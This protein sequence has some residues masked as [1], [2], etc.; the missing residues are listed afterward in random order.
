MKGTTAKR[1]NVR[2]A[3]PG[4]LARHRPDAHLEWIGDGKIIGR[5]SLWWNELPSWNDHA[6]G[7]IGHYSASGDG[8][9]DFLECACRQLRDHGCT[10]AVGP[11]DG[12]TWRSYRFVTRFG[13][14][15]RFFFEPDNPPEFVDHFLGSGFEPLATYFSALN[16]D[17][18]GTDPRITRRS[19]HLTES[20]I[21]L[22]PIRG[23]TIE[24]D[25]CRI[26]TVSRAAFRDNL[27]YA[28]PDKAEFLEAWRPL[29][30]KVPLELILLAEHAGD[31]VGFVFAIPDLNE[32]S[33]QLEGGST[34]PMSHRH[35]TVVIK[36]LA[37]LPHRQYAGLG[38]MLLAEVLRRALE[39]GFS[40]AIHAL[41]RD[42][43]HLRR[44][45]SRF[46][47]PIREYTLF[48]RVLPR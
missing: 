25:L 28:D 37:A 24:D 43:G 23:E 30:G 7:M 31:P 29:L 14:E 21:T 8:A 48:A 20:G 15:P 10:L 12:S 47:R 35:K 32:S 13:D 1:L 19:A 33:Q 34:R 26:F 27:L 38:Q 11:I 6:V 4:D 9:S 36:T 3:D 40:R 5:C 44:I 39:L 42:S 45:T 17:L 2:N 46:A 18:T 16:D 22:R 41:I